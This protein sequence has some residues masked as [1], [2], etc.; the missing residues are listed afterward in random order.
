MQQRTRCWGSSST[1]SCPSPLHLPPA[2]CLPRLSEEEVTCSKEVTCFHG[3]I[4][5]LLSPEAESM[6]PRSI[7]S[8]NVRF[9]T[10]EECA[11]PSTNHQMIAQRPFCMSHDF[12]LQ[13]CCFCS[14]PN[15]ANANAKPMAMM[16]CILAGAGATS[17]VSRRCGWEI[18]GV[19]ATGRET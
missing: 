13:L 12:L 8:D 5:H 17:A 6:F 11:T 1:L 18:V 16:M 19:G 7:K 2:T 9:R 15:S 14:E 3:V 4:Q 10:N